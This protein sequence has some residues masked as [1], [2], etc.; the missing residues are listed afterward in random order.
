MTVPHAVQ[1]AAYPI[2]GP[3]V[4][5]NLFGIY[6]MGLLSVL[7]VQVRVSQSREQR[8]TTVTDLPPTYIALQDGSLAACK[9]G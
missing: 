7:A 1:A 8:A 2:A 5:G 4:M 3:V 6:L 9:Q